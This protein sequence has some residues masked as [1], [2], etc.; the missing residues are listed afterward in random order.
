MTKSETAFLYS[1]LVSPS[2]FQDTVKLYEEEL[3]RRHKKCDP[4]DLDVANVTQQILSTKKLN[5]VTDRWLY[6]TGTDV[7]ASNSHENLI[8]ETIV[9][10]KSGQFLVQTGKREVCTLEVYQKRTFSNIQ[11]G[12]KEKI[13]DEYG[14]R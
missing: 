7:E 8:P 10:I 14:V 5:R 2:T 6:D 12:L 11:I 1:A 4:S 9:K 3:D 13:L